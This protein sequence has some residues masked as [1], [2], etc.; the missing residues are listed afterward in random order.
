MNAI[1][2]YFR[3]T[4]FLITMGCFTV[5]SI[6]VQGQDNTPFVYIGADPSGAKGD[7][8]GM[9]ATLDGEPFWEAIKPYIGKTEGC[10]NPQ[11]SATD[12]VSNQIEYRPD[13]SPEH[14]GLF[15]EGFVD[16]ERF[17]RE[18]NI[19]PLKRHVLM[20]SDPNAPN[21]IP[22]FCSIKPTPNDTMLP[23]AI[24]LQ[25]T[26]GEASYFIIDKT[27]P[28]ETFPDGE[29]FVHRKDREHMRLTGAR[30]LLSSYLQESVLSVFYEHDNQF[31]GDS[32]NTSSELLD[33]TE[34][35]MFIDT[36]GAIIN[37]MTVSIYEDKYGY[38]AS[39]RKNTGRSF[40]NEQERFLFLP[41]QFNEAFY[42]NDVHKSK[43]TTSG[44]FWHFLFNGYLD[45]GYEVVPNLLVELFTSPNQI[46]IINN[47]IDS[48]DGNYNNGLVHAVPNFAA[49]YA[50]WFWFRSFLM[51]ED[52]WYK[53]V[54]DECSE[55]T[56]S[57]EKP[58][59]NLDIEIAAYASTCIKLIIEGSGETTISD[60]HIKAASEK[61]DRKIDGLE[62]G[63]GYIKKT[64]LS[65]GLGE[66]NCYS[67]FKFAKQGSAQTNIPKG[68]SEKF[69][70]ATLFSQGKNPTTKG[71]ERYYFIAN[72]EYTGVDVGGR[73][74][75]I[76]ASYVPGEHTATMEKDAPPLNG[77]LTFSSDIAQLQSVL[78][79]EPSIESVFGIKS[80]S[81]PI[82][83]LPT[84]KT[85][86]FNDKVMEGLA[87]AID[88]A[89]YKGAMAFAER[90]FGLRD[91][92]GTEIGFE[93]QGT[94]ILNVTAGNSID[95]IPVFGKEGYITIPNPDKSSQ[96]NIIQ[97]DTDTLHFE[98]D[99]HICMLEQSEIIA[100]SQQRYI[101][102]CKEGKKE[103][104]K[105]EASIPFPA[106][107]R[108]SSMIVW[109][110][111]DNYA[112][113]RKFRVAQ[114]KQKFSDMGMGDAAPSS[115]PT[116]SPTPPN[117]E[118]SIS[119]EVKSCSVFSA[120]VCDCS[121]SAKTCLSE[122]RL[123]KVATGS[124]LSCRLTCG[125]KWRLCGN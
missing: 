81:T 88:P 24:V 118:T 63:T 10:T 85:T 84:E 62:L 111:T 40:S 37:A 42:K 6:Q 74:F 54:F 32:K 89:L 34:F 106:Q 109:E 31:F 94:D 80:G 70:C 102:I 77:T 8:M 125:K 66:S 110:E 21:A 57:A 96:I 49:T 41:G 108:P 100:K 92:N 43:E 30:A 23:K 1:L 71:L 22:I 79:D 26:T 60:V 105:A 39:I 90:N 4:C 44:A 112:A 11:I 7:I 99:A 93:M 2:Q 91:D 119:S 121:C 117:D 83:P 29:T 69:T 116:S 114:I 82:A 104:I 47:Y 25:G 19:W 35:D 33:L 86:G 17:L 72:T 75:L 107:Y 113:A 36:L 52:F 73:V 76:T 14:I 15:L 115:P 55:V 101:D 45:V 53:E 97:N 38:A 98:A 123:K 28:Y 9:G 13:I 48:H 59:E 20:S 12:L 78:F 27:L 16:T 64:E 65:R 68:L 5:V 122:K 50:G 87:T 95:F 124:E 46:K 56:L 18:K 120:T 3:A 103:T 51:N 61:T 58:T 67:A